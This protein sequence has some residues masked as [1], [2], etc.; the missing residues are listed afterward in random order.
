MIYKF[1]IMMHTLGAA[2]WIGGHAV[3]VF[4]ILPRALRDGN[5]GRVLDFERSYGRLGLAALATQLVTGLWL[6]SRWVGQWSTILSDPTPQ[7]RLVLLKLL[8]L[9]LTIVLAGFTHHR[10]LP[11]INERGLRAF[12]MLSGGATVLAIVMLVL[13]I[14]IRTGGLA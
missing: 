4:A 11:R 6:A 3:L 13:G 12:A 1:M 5:A 14:G 7:G 2:I 8:A 9:A 10:V